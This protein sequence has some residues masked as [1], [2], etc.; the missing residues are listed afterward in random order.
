[1]QKKNEIFCD[2][3]QYRNLGALS[4]FEGFCQMLE[5]SL[6]MRESI[7]LSLSSNAFLILYHVL[8]HTTLSCVFL[9]TFKLLSHCSVAKMH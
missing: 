4:K 1:M 3:N 5:L 9:Y 8:V 6:P 2:V 7:Q